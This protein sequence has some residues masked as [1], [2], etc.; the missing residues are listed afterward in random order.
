MLFFL[1][2][3]WYTGVAG[4]LSSSFRLSILS[5][6]RKVD[7]WPDSVI[8]F[9]CHG[10]MK[11]KWLTFSSFI[12]NFASSFFSFSFPIWSLTFHIQSRLIKTIIAA[13]RIRNLRTNCKEKHFMVRW[14]SA[15]SIECFVASNNQNKTCFTVMAK[16]KTIDMNAVVSLVRCGIY[17]HIYWSFLATV[18]AFLSWWCVTKSRK[19]F[20]T[21]NQWKLTA[22]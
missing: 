19:G 17:F 20:A 21:P 12:V 2:E 16:K 1:N 10:L 7:C 18:S 9:E 13:E 5:C 3:V 15:S 6:P 22:Y 14:A 8:T 11:D 4:D